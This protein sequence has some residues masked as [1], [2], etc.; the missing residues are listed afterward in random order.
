MDK[1]PAFKT[2]CNLCGT[3]VA[4][5]ALTHKQC[6]I[7]PQCGHTIT[8]FRRYGVTL[9]LSTSIS[10]LL[11]LCLSLP[12]HF[13]SFSA[14]GQHREIDIPSGLLTMIELDFYS[15]AVITALATLVLPGMLLTG[16][17]ALSSCR[18]QNIKPAWLPRV[19]KAVR[20]I[21]PW[22]M[23]EIFLVGTLVSL[24]KI[25]DI[26]TIDI[27]VSFIAFCLFI[28]CITVAVFYYDDVE[29]ANWLSVPPKYTGPASSKEKTLSVQ[30]TWALLAT[31]IILY[32]FCQC[33]YSY[34]KTD[35]VSMV[36]LERAN[37]LS[38]A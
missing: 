27:G 37:R 10:A 18:V 38:N 19:H 36:K 1:Q 13:L 35:C 24:I 25:A 32:I 22:S 17:V 3:P 33:G 26:A 15:L 14:S 30:Q 34:R 20:Q 2:H 29:Y 28:V 16:L 31:A 23:A 7:C 12:Y 5:P 8:G 4:V 21:L 6:A 9:T 11:F